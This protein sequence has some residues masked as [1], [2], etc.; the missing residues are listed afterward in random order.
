MTTRCDWEV[1]VRIKTGIQML[2]LVL[3][4]ALV[5][6]GGDD[7]PPV[8]PGTGG[9]LGCMGS[10]STGTA[11]GAVTGSFTGCAMFD[12]QG[13]VGSQDYSLIIYAGTSSTNTTF[14]IFAYADGPR[15][16][17]G[18][19]NVGTGATDLKGTLFKDGGSSGPDR[20]F[21]LTSGSINITASA[22]TGLTGTYNLTGTELSGS[23]T[24]NFSGSFT[25]KCINQASTC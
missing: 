11:T 5:G 7:D 19:H 8:G 15:P 14:S 20:T 23:A 24:A 22:T 2:S 13:D 25:A 4:V 10:S 21:V 17:V 12:V 3:G 18:T 9:N 6:C 1:S 16:A